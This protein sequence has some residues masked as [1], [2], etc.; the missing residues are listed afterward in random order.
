M[1]GTNITNTERLTYTKSIYNIDN[2]LVGESISDA[3][4]YL[5]SLREQHPDAT[6]ERQY[7][8]ESTSLSLD[9]PYTETEEEMEA[10][11]KKLELSLECTK[12]RKLKEYE[13]LKKELGL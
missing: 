10:R 9:Y 12:A 8:Y 11:I 4:L 5:E 3:I 7:D 2:H 13:K 6:I 1:K